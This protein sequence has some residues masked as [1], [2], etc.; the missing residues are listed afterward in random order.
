MDHWMDGSTLDEHKVWIYFIGHKT[1]VLAGKYGSCKELP[2]NVHRLTYRQKYQISSEISNIVGNIN[3]CRN[4]CF[5]LTVQKNS[6]V[7]R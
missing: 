3:Q 2:H 4:S 6:V 5:R 7:A 1:K